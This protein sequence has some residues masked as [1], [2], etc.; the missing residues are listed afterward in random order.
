[1]AQLLKKS[2]KFYTSMYIIISL[3]IIVLSV[4]FM[5]QYRYITQKY[6]VLQS[7]LNS[8][9]NLIFYTGVLAFVGLSIN[10]IIG[11]TNR[12]HFYKFNLISGIICNTIP[13]ILGLV[14]LILTITII[15]SLSSAMPE[16]VR[17]AELLIYKFTP[18]MLTIYVSL[19]LLITFITYSVLFSLYFVAKYNHELT[20]KKVV[21]CDG[22]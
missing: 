16:L 20:L 5:T 8:I 9:N 10:L 4:A 14:S 13:A 21:E 17:R 2:G 18:S 3:V 6:E 12:R 7:N 15:P 19:A 1:M 22:K 11:N